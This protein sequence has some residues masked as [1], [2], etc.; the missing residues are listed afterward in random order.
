M[1]RFA[2]TGVYT[3]ALSTGVVRGVIDGQDSLGEKDNGRERWTI[4]GEG[5]AGR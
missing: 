5:R 4:R 3:A 2:G 1:F